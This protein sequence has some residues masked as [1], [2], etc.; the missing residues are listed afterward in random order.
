MDTKNALSE[1]IKQMALLTAACEGNVYHER[2]LTNEAIFTLAVK[3][4]TQLLDISEKIP[5]KA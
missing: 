3:I 1:V 4:Q 5:A 2:T